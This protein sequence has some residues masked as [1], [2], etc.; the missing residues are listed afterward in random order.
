[1]HYIIFTIF[2]LFLIS[3]LSTAR[4]YLVRDFHLARERVRRNDR[5]L[6]TV[7][8]G[9]L[10]GCRGEGGSVERRRLGIYKEKGRME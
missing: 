4:K 7:K 6:R 2:I 1:M 5:Q 10:N 8:D 9:G 3:L